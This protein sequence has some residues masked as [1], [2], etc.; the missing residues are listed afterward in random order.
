M[1]RL[2][3]AASQSR[4]SDGGRMASPLLTAAAR[5]RCAEKRVSSSPNIHAQSARANA[6]GS[7]SAIWP[8]GSGRGEPCSWIRPRIGRCHRRCSSSH[9]PVSW[10]QG[11][12]K[13]QPHQPAPGGCFPNSRTRAPSGLILS[14][15]GRACS[16]LPDAFDGTCVLVRSPMFPHSRHGSVGSPFGSPRGKKPTL[17]RKAC[18][19][20]PDAGHFA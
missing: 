3:V 14:P 18:Q 16:R 10:L 6:P 1:S 12:Q 19:E 5:S 7:R 2:V 8:G 17:T 9:L 15:R 13:Y 20:Q 4:S 11:S